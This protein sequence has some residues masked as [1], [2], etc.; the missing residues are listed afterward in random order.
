MPAR[1]VGAA[2][3]NSIFCRIVPRGHAQRQRGLHHAPR[4]LRHG[5][6]RVAHDGQQRVQRERD[7]RRH[8]ADA[9]R[10]RNQCGQQCQ[11]RDRLHHAGRA[12]NR[13]LRSRDAWRRVCRAGCRRRCWR[14]AT[15]RRATAVRSVRRA[16]SG[17][18]SLSPKERRCPSADAALTAAVAPGAAASEVAPVR[19]ARKPQRPPRTPCHRV[20]RH[21]FMRRIGGV[22]DG[23]FELGE[24]G[25]GLV[26][27]AAADPRDR[28]TR[29]RSA[30]NTC[31]RRRAPSTRTCRSWRRS[32]RCRS[33]RPAVCAMASY[34]RP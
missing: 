22:V 3:G 26:A 33:H 17:P 1:I 32:S 4:D 30:G 15:G 8:R 2:S 6:M 9:P 28:A 14:R 20:R 18:K 23:A 25:P 19:C 24:R 11:R 29:R 21:A 10:Q 5:G 16:K 12:E 27:D 31:D 13:H 7:E 34:A